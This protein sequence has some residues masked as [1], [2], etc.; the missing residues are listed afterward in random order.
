MTKRSDGTRPKAASH[1]C[2]EDK[3]ALIYNGIDIE[4]FQQQVDKRTMCLELGLD[5]ECKIVGMIGR[6]DKQKNHWILFRQPQLW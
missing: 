5:P 3:F 6:L 1:E 2:R 4:K